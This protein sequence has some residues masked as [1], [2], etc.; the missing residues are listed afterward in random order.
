MKDSNKVVIKINYQNKEKGLEKKSQSKMIT[1]WNVKRILFAFILLG[2]LIGLSVYFFIREPILTEPALI[3][4]QTQVEKKPEQLIRQLD[5][6]VKQT[7]SISSTDSGIKSDTD[8]KKEI[9]FLSEKRVLENVMEDKI[10]EAKELVLAE[11]MNKKPL[12]LNSIK[13]TVILNNE[14]VIVAS[15]V[16]SNAIDKVEKIVVES[17]DTIIEI[18]GSRVVRA[19]LTSKINNKEPSGSIDLPI[20]ISG[21]KASGIIYFTEIV[22]MK[23]QDIYHEWIWKGQVVFRKKIKILGDRWR[24]STSKL[25]TR[26]KVGMWNVR[27]V[28]KES[29]IL[30]ELNFEVFME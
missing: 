7:V 1:E 24:A 5:K 25:L 13:P 3:S 6:T 11:N 9:N 18:V 30:N 15:D 23:G 26:S 17:N 20:I 21:N 10:K 12:P 16:I 4:E 29:V 19:L 14:P 8:I 27:L 28:N 22:N 2:G